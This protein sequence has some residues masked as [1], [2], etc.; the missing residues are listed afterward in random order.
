[1]A[2]KQEIRGGELDMQCEWSQA[3][4]LLIRADD[5][6]TY[7]RALMRSRPTQVRAAIREACKVAPSG[8]EVS[9]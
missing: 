7:I 4:G 5:E 3:I 2:P 9:T 1:V 6:E 8:G